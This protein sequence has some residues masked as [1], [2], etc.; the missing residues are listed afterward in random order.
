[1]TESVG[2][3]VVAQTRMELALT[4]RRGENVLI[5]IVVPIVLLVFFASLG[6]VPATS[7][8]PMDYLVPGILA[9]AI[10]STGMVNLGIATAYER[11]YGVLK[12]LGGSPLPRWGLL[13]AKALSVLALE[14]FQVVL[15][16]V[17][18]V[19]GYG[20]FPHGGQAALAIVG[21]VLGTLAFSAIGLAM[22][23]ALRAEATLAIANGLYLLFLLLGD[24]LMPTDHLPPLLRPLSEVLPATAL[25]DTLR[26]AF[27]GGPAFP[28]FSTLLL[29]VWAI[30]ALVV[31]ARTFTWE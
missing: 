1:M 10:I 8:G 25:S 26:F 17:V 18:A 28:T 29:L 31:A 3:A 16:L 24:V 15:L 22:A 13:L 11:Y 30:A 12:R 2:R 23:G 9:L 7:T 27:S 6:L 14:V 4:L 5:T 20:W 21:L 19:V